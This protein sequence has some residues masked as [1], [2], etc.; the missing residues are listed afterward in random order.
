MTGFAPTGGS[1]KP[2]ITKTHAKPFPRP[3]FI[4]VPPI[5]KN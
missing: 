5:K 1:S 2:R 3:G 4:V